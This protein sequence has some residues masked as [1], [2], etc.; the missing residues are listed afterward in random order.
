MILFWDATH[1]DDNQEWHL[2][3]SSTFQGTNYPKPF[4]RR[5]SSHCVYSICKVPVGR[6]SMNDSVNRLFNFVPISVWFN[7]PGIQAK[8]PFLVLK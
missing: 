7:A 2:S 6:V 8:I 3:H 4:S 1:F 5:E